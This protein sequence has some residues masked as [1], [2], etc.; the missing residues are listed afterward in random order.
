MVDVADC[1]P[2]ILNDVTQE[3]DELDF[4]FGHWG[5]GRHAWKLVRVKR[6]SHAIPCAGAQGL[7]PVP[8]RVWE[9]VR[10]ALPAPGVAGA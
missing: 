8:Q 4:R 5:P 9:L 7:W 2:T 6:L 1:Y 3:D 10:R